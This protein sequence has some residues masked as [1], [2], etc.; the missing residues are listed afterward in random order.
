MPSSRGSSP[1]ALWIGDASKHLW[2]SC[3]YRKFP[4]GGSTSSCR[5]WFH[6]QPESWESRLPGWWIRVE[7][8]WANTQGPESHYFFPLKLHP[9]PPDSSVPGERLP[10]GCLRGCPLRKEAS[11][12]DPS[13][14]RPGTWWGYPGSQDQRVR[15]PLLGCTRDSGPIYRKSDSTGLRGVSMKSTLQGCLDPTPVQ[16]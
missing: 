15:P 7:G 9:S 1:Q 3:N 10:G 5:L 2:P 13:T 4:Q 8:A 16:P 11:A 14:R 6:L 12:G